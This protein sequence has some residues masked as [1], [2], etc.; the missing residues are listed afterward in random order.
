MRSAT[1]AGRAVVFACLLALATASGAEVVRL[2]ATADIWLSDANEQ[3][4]NTSAGK[5]DRIKLKT[6]QEMAAIRFDAS[7]AAGREIHRATLY[8]RR[9]SSDMLRYV[10]VSTVN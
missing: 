5:H 6:I 2:N 3:E 1:T 10:R 9:A 7:P 8:L 4:R